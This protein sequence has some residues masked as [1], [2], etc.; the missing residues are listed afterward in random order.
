M[1]SVR[2]L[3]NQNVKP[4]QW[5]GSFHVM[6]A[7]LKEIIHEYYLLACVDFYFVMNVVPRSTMNTNGETEN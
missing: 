1:P 6:G 7:C 4:E 5:T 2:K 3:S